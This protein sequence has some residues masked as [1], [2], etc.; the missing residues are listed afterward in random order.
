MKK[1]EFVEFISRFGKHPIPATLN[2]HVYIWVGDIDELIS[3]GPVGLIK[4]LDLYVL[5]EGLTKTPLGDKA[6]GR[7]LSDAIDNWISREFPTIQRQRA[8]MVTGLALLYRYGLPLSSFIR[9]ANET[10]MVIF[11]LTDLDI[12]FRPSQTMPS[13][14]QF[15]PYSILKYVAS[16]IPEEAI[17]KEE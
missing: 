5:C 1:S 10:T 13:Y 4:K 12:N 8:L 9:L 16:E 15:A 14:I 3:K 6:A 17:V 2:R 7:V 11:G